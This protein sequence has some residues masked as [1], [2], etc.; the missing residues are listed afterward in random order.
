ML[1]GLAGDTRVFV[2]SN[3][4]IYHFSNFEKFAEACL[5][6]FQKIEDGKLSGYTST[7]A[8]AEVLHG[9]MVMEASKKFNISP[10]NVV[11]NLKDN[12]DWI[13]SLC[14]HSK[15]LDF[16]ENIGIFILPVNAHDLK[17]SVDLKIQYR[18]LTMDAINLSVM[19]NNHI[20]DIASNDGDFDRVDFI[21]RH[22]P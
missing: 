19:K 14:D 10:K 12:P 6:F 13:A 1:S 2:D 3:I 17:T 9:L 4:F 5:D 20:S 15:S 18:L 8:L 11:K 7:L 22:T 16:I 21:T